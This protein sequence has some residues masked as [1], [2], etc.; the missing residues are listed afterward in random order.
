MRQEPIL[1]REKR[2]NFL[3]YRFLHRGTERRVRRVERTWDVAAGWGRRA[4]HYFRVRCH[5]DQ[6]YDVF[7]DVELNAWF[8]RRPSWFFARGL[9]NAAAK[10]KLRWTFI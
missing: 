10:G 2:F 4:G 8:V 9:Q 1:V 7:H 3:P 5:D 6:T